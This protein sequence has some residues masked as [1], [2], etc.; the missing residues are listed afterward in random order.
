MRYQLVE[1]GSSKFWEAVVE[2]NALRLTWGRIGTTG[3]TKTKRFKSADQARLAHDKLVAEKTKKGYRPAKKP[4]KAAKVAVTKAKTKTKSGID[5]T[6]ALIE[7]LGAKLATMP[8]L[9]VS[10]YVLRPSL[11]AAIA[12]VERGLSLT[13]PSDVKAFLARGLRGVQGSLEEPFATVGFDFL[14]AKKMLEHTRMLRKVVEKNDDDDEHARVI[15]QGV[16]LTA[17][18]P[19]LV[20]SGGA[21]YHFSFRNPLLKV[22]SSFSELMEHYVAAGCF[23]SHAF[24]ALWK[25]VSRHVPLSIPPAKNVWISAYKKQFPGFW[26]S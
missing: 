9:H 11:P 15:R 7:E 12:A 14:S 24:P 19:E 13:L 8:E 23:S 4:P 22:A 10:P 17:S 5:T 20:L 16:A 3:Q 25:V 26:R 21:I 6:A 1:G 2:G 18:E